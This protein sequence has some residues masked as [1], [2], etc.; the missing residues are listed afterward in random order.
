MRSR[1]I[2]FAAGAIV[3]FAAAAY[4][5]ATLPTPSDPR[6]QAVAS[7]SGKVFGSVDFG[8]QFSNVRGDIAR[9]QRYRDL[10]DRPLLDNL[11]FN[12]RGETW[13]LR[14][15][16]MKMGYRDQRFTGE[17]RLIGKLKASVDWNQ[18]PLFISAD[19]RTLYN[20]TEPGVFRL[21]DS[22]QTSN[23]A[24]LTTIRNFV[25]DA[26]GFETRTRR[27]IGTFDL[28]YNANRD[29]DLKFTVT[30]SRRAGAIPYGATFGFS[31]LIELPAP[32]DQRT[33]DAKALLEWANPHALVS[34]GW[35]GSWFTNNV[36]RMIW[37]NPLKITDAPSYATAYSDGKGPAQARMALWPDS[38]LQYV[39]GTGS[40]TTPGRGRL[41]AY[42]AVG[43][44]TQNASLLPH[45]INS[46][47][48]VVPLERATADTEVRN[49]M[50]NVQ[51]VVRPFRVLSLNARY[52]YGDVDNRTPHFET[53]GRVRFDGVLDDAASSPEPEPYSVRRKN[54]DVDGSIG[55]IPYASVKIGYSGAIT[56][57]TFRIWETTTENTMRVSVDTTGNRFVT[58]RAL[59]E[60]GT[61]EG[62]GF[63]R[64][65]ILEAVGEQPG[66]RHYDIADRDRKRFTLIATVMAT[67]MFGVNASAGVGREDYPDSEFGLKRLDSDQY[68]VGF[69]FI[70]GDR[71]GVN[72]VYA[73]EDYGSLTQSRSASPGVQF[74]DPRRD[75]FMDYAGKVKNFDAAVD[76]VDLAPRTDL[77][78]GVNW[79]DVHDAYVYV[80]PAV[81]TLATPSQLAPVTNELFRG[82]VDLAH[83]VRPRVRLGV[84]YWYEEYKT[85]DFALGSQII[86]D[87]ALPTI[88]PG[89]TPVP[90]STLLLGYM[91][92]P[93]RAHTAIVRLTYLW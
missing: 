48:P 70:P 68:S 49:T 90:T 81:T 8:G 13:T 77:R 32:I 82:T 17:Y 91:Y 62:E 72:V 85:E 34:V 31:N 11:L 79:S 28:I 3:A 6:D 2:A 46:M 50:F 67:A 71:V 56:D 87:I 78:L 57:R 80:L 4:A 73:W 83:K 58:F 64:H 40:I 47:I 20:E 88:Q 45:T 15:A 24:G 42:L 37:D 16:A 1:M 43:A 66:M 39:H 22:M 26:T 38:M 27:N 30:S 55:A 9:F 18:I 93:Y 19:T 21:P 10:R 54:F 69:D 92:R 41:T 5:Q 25:N 33:T 51:Y 7:L 23:Q 76:V 14:A 53:L 89:A 65:G 60:R 63:D 36:E 75:W 35:D 74:T 61:R 86:S 59:F 29:V 52:R 84:S 44:S 12:R